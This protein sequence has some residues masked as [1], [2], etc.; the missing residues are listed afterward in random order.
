MTHP[1]D[2][3]PRPA[4]YTTVPVE[5]YR[6]RPPKRYAALGGILIAVLVVG[7]GI[8]HEV[9]GFFLE[10]KAAEADARHAVPDAENLVTTFL[11]TDAA[12]PAVYYATGRRD[13]HVT[14]DRCGFIVFGGSVGTF[15]ITR[16]VR[17]HNGSADVMVDV[18]GTG[19]TSL[20]FH[21]V[22]QDGWKIWHF[23]CDR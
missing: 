11:G 18:D 1:A 2:H 7:G 20:R 3:G 12:E 17:E 23:T 19:A 16:S 8:A 13:R 21:L 5:S 4:T 9:G 14:D 10:R 15:A 22:Q 6:P